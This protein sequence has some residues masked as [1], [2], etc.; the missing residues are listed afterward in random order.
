MPGEAGV[1]EKHFRYLQG[2][3][4]IGHYRAVH[5]AVREE[6]PG[7]RST[8]DGGFW[9]VSRMEP[10]RE[11]FGNPTAFANSGLSLLDPDPVDP[12]IPM[13]LDPPVHTAWRKPLMSEFSPA[14]ARA[15]EPVVRGHVTEL[16]DGLLAKGSCDFVAE[17]AQR[18]PVAVFLTMLDLPQT[19]L[20]RFLAW[21]EAVLRP[22]EAEQ[23][24]DEVREQVRAY[25]GRLVDS[26]VAEPGDDLV[27][28]MLTWR[29]DGREAKRE[30]LTNLLFVLFIAGLDTISAHLSYAFWHLATNP[31]DR[32]RVVR[33]PEIIPSAV[34][35]LLR[36]YDII[37]DGRRVTEDVELAGCPMRAGDLVLLLSGAANRDPREFDRA[38][39]VLLDRS[40]N[41]HLTFGWGIH[42]CVGAHLARLE[43][44]V[45]LEEWHRRIPDYR[46]PAGFPVRERAFV[47]LSVESLPLRWT[48]AG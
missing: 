41:R 30:E 2:T 35:E 18:L 32:E 46:I 6:C 36:Y 17:F 21:E 24:L 3:R 15:L 14:R 13:Q 9:V 19:E 4:R 12:A 47:Q 45:A 20:D 7:F 48:T 1:P 28:R 39:E 26:R 8:A 37:L 33:E 25:F 44:K 38:E 29:I 40:P 22:E 27:S 23:D 16:I 43:L 11:L 5:D 10:L 31:A 34:E 42:R